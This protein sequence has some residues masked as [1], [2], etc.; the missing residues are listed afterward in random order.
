MLGGVNGAWQA[1]A[2]ITLAFNLDPP[3]G[4]LISKRR[5][6]LEIDW[7]PADLE[8][9]LPIA[10]RVGPRHV[11]RPVAHVFIF[12]APH[13]AF[14]GRG[15][16][17]VDVVAES[18]QLCYFSLHLFFSFGA[19][20]ALRCSPSSWGRE[21]PDD[22][23]LEC[24]WES[25]WLHY[26]GGPSDRRPRSRWP[27]SCTRPSRCPRRSRA[28]PRM[29]S[30]S[31]PPCCNTVRHS[32]W[33]ISAART[34]QCHVQSHLRL[35]IR[36]RRRLRIPLRHE[37]A[38]RTGIRTVRVRLARP[39]GTQRPTAILGARSDGD[40]SSVLREL[41]FAASTVTLGEVRRRCLQGSGAAVDQCPMR[42][43]MVL[44]SATVLVMGEQGGMV[45]CFAQRNNAQQDAEESSSRPHRGQKMMCEEEEIV[46]RDALE[47]WRKK[48]PR[49]FSMRRDAM[50]RRDIR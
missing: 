41:A 42:Q 50:R 48:C 3:V 38:G 33:K 49:G 15:S 7:I 18:C 11:W 32:L 22:R 2:S 17:W 45:A 37:L 24:W 40:E 44:V 28:C 12:G 13:A 25:T 9:G 46:R 30:Q 34:I 19:R 14:L 21:R 29:V 35:R 39:I 1:I 43:R 16:W 5:G 4:H 10:V 6:R 36:V 8:E 31:C 26:P 23:Y 47:S 27:C 20:T